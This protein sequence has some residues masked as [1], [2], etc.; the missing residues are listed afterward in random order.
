MQLHTVLLIASTLC[1]RLATPNHACS[2]MSHN[3]VNSYEYFMHHQSEDSCH[4]LLSLEWLPSFEDIV[5]PLSTH[6]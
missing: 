4:G 5:E 3:I 1:L 6:I 2:H